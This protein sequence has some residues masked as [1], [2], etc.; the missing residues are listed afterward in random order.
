MLDALPNGNM[1][2]APALCVGV[3]VVVGVSAR[4]C[5]YVHE[6]VCVC[7]CVCPMCVPSHPP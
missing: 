3:W 1:L 6:C 5:V 4:V 7:A 2:S